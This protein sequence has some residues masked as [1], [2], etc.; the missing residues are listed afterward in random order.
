MGSVVQNVKVKMLHCPKTLELYISRTTGYYGLK[1]CFQNFMDSGSKVKISL[2][3]GS[4]ILFQGCSGRWGTR[5]K[6]RWT[7][8]SMASKP[9]KAS[10]LYSSGYIVKQNKTKQSCGPLTV[11]N[12]K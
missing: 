11:L 8:D 4:R 2:A 1:R 10:A 6:P 3:Y 9:Y 12:L 5:L 7:Q